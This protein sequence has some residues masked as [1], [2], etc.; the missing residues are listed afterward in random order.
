MPPITT[1]RRRGELFAAAF[2][3]V[4]DIFQWGNWSHTQKQQ[5]RDGVRGR[6]KHD[7]R[8]LLIKIPFVVVG[9]PLAKT[10][11]IS[12]MPSCNLGLQDSFSREAYALPHGA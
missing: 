9:R 8:A 10:Y 3:F 7:T 12:L 4:G 5:R 6:K 1:R 11:C 2:K